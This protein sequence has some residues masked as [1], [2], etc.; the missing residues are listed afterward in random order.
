MSSAGSLFDVL[1]AT[2]CTFKARFHSMGLE[3]SLNIDPDNTPHH[4]STAHIP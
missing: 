3:T 2:D 4:S 1:E